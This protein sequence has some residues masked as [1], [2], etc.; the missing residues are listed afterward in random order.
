MQL[1]VALNQ[2]RRQNIT[3]VHDHLVV[4][5]LLGFL[6]LGLRDNVLEPGDVVLLCLDHFLRGGDLGLDLFDGFVVP[7]AVIL[8]E[9]TLGILR[10]FFVVL[11]DRFFFQLADMSRQ[12]L[13]TSSQL[14]D[15]RIGFQQIL[16]VEVPI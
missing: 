14:S 13:E 12:S 5:L 9:A 8:V 4:L 2:L 10:L 1:L 16:R 3:L 6:C 7:G 11:D 15:L